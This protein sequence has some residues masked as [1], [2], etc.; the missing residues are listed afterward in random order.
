M[1]RFLRKKEHTLY[2]SFKFMQLSRFYQ[3]LKTE[4]NQKMYLKI[5]IVNHK[6]NQ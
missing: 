1:N 5:E 6:I 4:L 2:S 3:K